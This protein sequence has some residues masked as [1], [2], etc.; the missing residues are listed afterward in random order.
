MKTLTPKPGNTCF[1]CGADNPLGLKLTF[2]GDPA[3]QTVWT[4]FQPPAFLAG[5]IDMMHGGFI[6]LLLDEVSSKTLSI[7][8]KRGVT[9]SLEVSF[10]KPV[11]L[12]QPIRLEAELIS[13]ERRKHFI[14]ARILNSQGVVLAQSKALFLVFTQTEA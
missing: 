8:G 10:D 12:N 1:G 11:P 9:R 13:S 14:D 2:H 7:L 4:E 5:A 3:T 6:S